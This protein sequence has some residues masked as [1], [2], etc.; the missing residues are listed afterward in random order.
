MLIILESKHAQWN[1]NYVRL[2]GFFSVAQKTAFWEQNNPRTIAL[3]VH[4]LYVI[5][6]PGKFRIPCFSTLFLETT[7][8][9][10]KNNICNTN[11]CYKIVF[12]LVLL[13]F[14]PCEVTHGHT[15][16]LLKRKNTHCA[17]ANFFCDMLLNDGTFFPTVLF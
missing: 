17:H 5:C 14:S 15:Y 3:H 4:I 16:N 10:K 12:R 6:Q 11:W 9:G 2:A 13:G 8:H 7:D 1:S